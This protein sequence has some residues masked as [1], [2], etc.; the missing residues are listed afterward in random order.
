[1][2]PLLWLIVLSQQDYKMF[3]DYVL[4]SKEKRTSQGLRFFWRI[5]DIKKQGYLTVFTINYFLRVRNKTPS[6]LQR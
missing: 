1:L 3:L 4:A 2:F 6:L 5:L